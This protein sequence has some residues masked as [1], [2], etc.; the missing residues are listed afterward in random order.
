MI[1]STNKCS[2]SPDDI[3]PI[4]AEFNF[5]DQIE[6]LKNF[7]FPKTGTEKDQRCFQ[8]QW[9]HRY[10]WI[11][12][13]KSRDA[14]FCN[15]CRQFGQ[16]THETKFTLTGYSAWKTALSKDKGFQRHSTSAEHLQAE[17]AQMEKRRRIASGT[18]VSDMLNASVLEKRRYY[19]K[20]ILEVISFLVGH[21]LA[22]RGDWDDEEKEEGG[23]FNGLFEFSME[24]DLRLLECQ[25]AMPPNVTY[26]SPNIQ[27]EFIEILA[28]TVRENIVKEIVQADCGFFTILFDG[29]KDKN[30]IECV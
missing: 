9:V 16:S 15:I 19:C 17:S 30:G 20:S 22:L 4:G 21:R 3:T 1:G 10:N 12:Y 8:L 24:K 13:S 25:K 6:K 5:N 26:K 14:V 28:H 11:E 23:L 29:T 18:S 27:N 7:A 2:T